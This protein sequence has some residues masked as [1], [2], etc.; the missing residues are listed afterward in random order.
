MRLLAIPICLTVALAA[1]CSSGGKKGTSRALA[2]TTTRA[3][4]RCHTP[5]LEATGPIDG[6]A[7]TGH[8]ISYWQ[9][10]NI[11]SRACQLLGYPGVTLADA[12]G[13]PIPTKDQ[14]SNGFI[15]SDQPPLTVKMP[16]GATA[17]FGL[18]THSCDAT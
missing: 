17:V 15:T 1:A 5:E 2:T 4:V 10:K 16:P 6:G 11:S 12:S 18:E 3:S 13:N 7:A 14:R 9:L 8:Q